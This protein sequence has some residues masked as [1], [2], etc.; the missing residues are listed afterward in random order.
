MF[1]S[2]EKIENGHLKYHK[3]SAQHALFTLEGGETI[4]NQITTYY[5][6]L[7]TFIMET[8]VFLSNLTPTSTTHDSTKETNPSLSPTQYNIHLPT[9]NLPKSQASMTN[10]SHF[11]TY[12]LLL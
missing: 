11:R 12:L 4:E 1:R 8:K 7:Q 3:K 5:N 9:L 2:S 6:S 10:G